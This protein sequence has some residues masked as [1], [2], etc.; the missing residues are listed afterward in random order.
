MVVMLVLGSAVS[1]AAPSVSGNKVTSNYSSDSSPSQQRTLLLASCFYTPEIMAVM[2]TLA[3]AMHKMQ[4]MSDE[5]SKQ[6]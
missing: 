3:L 6:L 1:A 5:S 4:E 2:L